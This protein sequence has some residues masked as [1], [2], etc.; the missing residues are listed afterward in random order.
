MLIEIF[1][2]PIAIAI[3]SGIVAVVVGERL[4]S[5]KVVR[6]GWITFWGAFAVAFLFN[7]I[8]NGTLGSILEGAGT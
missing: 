8:D 7:Q 4:P 1:T 5:R 3:I 2:F 6:S